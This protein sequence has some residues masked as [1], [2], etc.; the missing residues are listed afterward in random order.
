M[1]ASPISVP[2]RRTARWLHAV[3]GVSAS[4]ALVSL[5][6]EFGFDKPPLPVPLLLGVQLTAVTVYVLSRIYD[7]WIAADR[8]AEVR[9][10]WP[11]A[12]LLL[13]ACVYLAVE[14]E[15]HPAHVLK[16]SAMY[17]GAMQVVLLVRL[18]IAGV[19]LNLML[20]QTR[21]QP[22]RVMAL[23]FLA[24]IFVGGLA[25]S[26]PRAIHH[27]V[28]ER[29]GFSIS[30]NILNGFFTAT[31]AT[32]VTG[33]IVYDTG[34]DFTLYG[35]IVILMLIQCGGLGIMIFGSA[36][37]MLAGRQLSLKQSL[38]LQ[39]AI[40]YR[41]LGH[42]RTMVIFIVLLTFTLEGIGAALLYP[43]WEGT[44][45]PGMRA[46]QSI[47][48]S[49][50][51]FCN[52][53]FALQGDSLIPYRRAWQVYG[54][55]M[56]LIVLGG[57]GFPVLHD[58]W[59]ATRAAGR[60]LRHRRAGLAWEFTGA[61][62]HRFTLHSKIVLCTTF[63]L[64]VV[65]TACFVIFES[66]PDVPGGSA[67]AG[68]PGHPTMSGAALP[69]RLLDA[70]FLAVTCRTAGFNTVATDVHSLSPAS[71]LLADI[72][73]FVGGSPASTA[74]G[75]KTV[76][77]AVL[78]IEVWCTLRGRSRVEA[79]GRTI[80][81]SLVRRAAA[82]VTVMFGVI[83]TVTLL[84]CL[85]ERASLREALFETISA[86]GTVGLSTG[87]TPHLTIAGRMLIMLA[88]FA[89]RLGPLTV[90]IA[91]AGRSRAAQYEYP[92]EQVGIG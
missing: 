32:C 35:Q 83:S 75:I 47:F 50:S 40:S 1:K 17:V 79:F 5:A 57:L 38:V 56:P 61:A 23:T 4:G 51:A 10:C 48:H 43:L 67:D 27:S 52:A 39:D 22:T 30:F 21:L 60:R 59:L 49:I 90:L 11:D 12:L 13:G 2:V 34:T 42:L 46:F 31:S 80:P 16:V 28:Q 58:L 70:L 25:L 77:M 8:L 65:P 63:V 66:F 45:S 85:T 89:G 84:L 26:L 88:M 55:I 64:I 76:A 68:T 44:T 74:G 37:G 87:L 18:L 82:V 92:T 3:V 91:L 72:L 20:S 62:R 81:G 33:L 29:D 14:L 86:C 7:I 71:H 54:C 6:L 53:G 78:L 36:F 9:A 15:R 73:M 69:L 19:R 41:T 24:L